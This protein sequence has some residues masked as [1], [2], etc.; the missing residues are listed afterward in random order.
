VG[1]GSNYVHVPGSVTKGDG[2]PYAV[3]TP[4]A[5]AWR[6]LPRDGVA[7]TP[8][9][10]WVRPRGIEAAEPLT[11]DWSGPLPPTT[12]AA[13]HQQWSDFLAVA[14]AYRDT[15]DLP[16]TDGTSRM[17]ASLRWGVV[18]PRTLLT[19]LDGDGDDR[20][21]VSE[22][23]WR[24]FYADVM[25]HRPQSAWR[26]V[27][28][29]MDALPTDDGPLARRRFEAWCA[30]RTGFP[31]VDAGMRQLLSTGWMHNRVR[32]IVASF[33][34]KDLHLPW[35]WGERFF[36]RHL[37]DGDR[38]SNV[39]GW[40]WTA[41]TGTD[42][43]PFFRVFNPTAQSERFDPEGRYIRTWVPELA[44][45]PDRSIHQPGLLRPDSYP[46]ALVD[47]AAERL[48]ALDRYR[49]TRGG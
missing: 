7:A 26:N 3:F 18:H 15:R 27:D 5:R 19:D 12:A 37:V 34:T 40:Q 35:Q 46:P 28:A 16:G 31:I 11:S 32:M 8:S 13:T 29:R 20:V 4:F 2:R 44:D 41:G 36:M 23:I 38:A 39:H 30:G 17:S 48:D 47:H 9:L 33:L 21:F 49:H 22:L 43:A 42:A 25:F 45:L 24:E 10:H 14:A 6:A 1:V